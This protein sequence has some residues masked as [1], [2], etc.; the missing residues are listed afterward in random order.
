MPSGEIKSSVQSIEAEAERILKEARALAS[1]I[2]L[3]ANQEASQI[4]SAEL[5]AEDVTAEH[6]SIVDRA[7]Q[8]AD[9]QIR[10]SRERAVEI[11]AKTSRKIDKVVERIVK[12]VTGAESV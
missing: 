5:S 9:K 12:L 3:K 2:L 6:D 11:Q 1:E 4:M 7:K 8:E 10:D